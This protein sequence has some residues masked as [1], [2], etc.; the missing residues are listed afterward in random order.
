[1]RANVFTDRALERYAGRF[2]WLAIDTEDGRNSGFL[3]RYPVTVWPTLLVIAPRD[4]EVALRYA[5]GATVPQL[6]KLLEDGERVVRGARGKADEAIARADRLANERKPAEAAQAYEEAIAAAPARW[7]RRGR[8]SESLTFS[9]YQAEDHER[10]ARRAS[11]LY[12]RV[13]GTYSAA[14]VAAIGISCAADLPPDHAGRGGLLVSL[15]QAARETLEDQA[16]PLSADDRSGLYDALIAAREAVK[17]EEGAR[18]LR[19]RWAAFLEDAAARARTP[20][21]RAAYDSHRLTAY[22]A[23]KQPRRAVPM[24]E[25]SERDLPADYNPPARLAVAYNAMGEHDQALAASD[26][27]LARA[28]GPRK[29]GILRTRADIYA[30]RG[31]HEAARRT[32]DEAIAF[33]E[34]LPPGQ[35]NEGAIASLKKKRAAM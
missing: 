4:G 12:P 35:R 14:N 16:I 26:R 20:E 21:Q 30:G 2:V 27:A 10:C 34:A 23:L 33:A 6:A 25:Q 13:K 9:L 31:D 19:E 5:G 22:L 29:I 8:A 32:I 18:K 15:E 17:D 3:T 24:L 7:S 28:Y 11:E 1:M